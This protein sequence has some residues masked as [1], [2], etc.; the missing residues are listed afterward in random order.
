MIDE[1]ERRAGERNEARRHA[2]TGE[3]PLE[4]LCEECN[5]TSSFPSEQAGTVQ[6]CPRC[7]AYVDVGQLDEGEPFWME[8]DEPDEA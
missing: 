4:V 7:G 3:P 5:Q 2:Q 1:Y 6:S 8:N